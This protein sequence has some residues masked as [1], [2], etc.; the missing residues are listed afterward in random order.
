MNLRTVKWYSYLIANLCFLTACDL[1]WGHSR[2]RNSVLR[3]VTS[4]QVFHFLY[5][6]VLVFLFCLTG[7]VP[8]MF[9]N[10]TGSCS[11]HSLIHPFD[12]VLRQPEVS[13]CRISPLENWKQEQQQACWWGSSVVFVKADPLCTESAPGR[14]APL[15]RMSENMGQPLPKGCHCR[16]WWFLV[17]NQ[18][19]QWRHQAAPGRMN[20]ERSLCEHGG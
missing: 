1:A 10:S 18:L 4:A 8:A 13:I 17:I 12:P 9:F 11:S 20:W 2:N 3:M 14:G 6:T 16:V 15:L 19:L 7:L 5:D